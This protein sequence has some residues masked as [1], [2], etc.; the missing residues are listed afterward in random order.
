MAD[1]LM[2][3]VGLEVSAVGAAHAYDDLL[4]AW[5]IDREDAGLRARVRDEIG[6]R[7]AVTDTVMRDDEVA[8][9][10]ARTALATLT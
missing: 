9:Q 5:V 4:D 7:V 10:V 1:R 3:V 2:P 8:E 6:A